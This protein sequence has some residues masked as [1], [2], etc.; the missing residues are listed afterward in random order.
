MILPWTRERETGREKNERKREGEARYSRNF[1][2][3]EAEEFHRCGGT[4]A[5]TIQLPP[6]LPLG[7]E[8]ARHNPG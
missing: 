3:N 4:F 2:I 1:G 7:V 8:D 6:V 5:Q